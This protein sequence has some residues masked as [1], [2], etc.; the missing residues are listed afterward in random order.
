MTLLYNS[1][2][3]IAIPN[4]AEYSNDIALFGGK[5]MKTNPFFESHVLAA[6]QLPFLFHLDDINGGF[7]VEP[8]WHPNMELLL[9]MKGEVVAEI[10]AEKFNMAP[11]EIYVVNSDVQHRMYSSTSGQYYCL[12]PD[13]KFCRLLGID[14]DKLYI[15]PRIQDAHAK[16]LYEAIVHTFQT[17]SPYREAEVKHAVFS[18]L[19]Y[20]SQHYAEEKEKTK[21]YTEKDEGVRIAVGYIRAHLNENF[22]LEELA[23][24]A[25]LS[26]FYFLRE[27]K[28]ATGD[29]P[30]AFIHKNR[31]EVAKALLLSGDLSAGE[32]AEQCGFESLSYF[33]RIF[34]KYVG[35][36]PGAYRRKS[37]TP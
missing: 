20:L 30:V 5:T 19:L 17:D 23:A 3:Q 1:C 8:H 28:K 29:T 7:W 10:G 15:A 21:D 22:T 35:C 37:I 4:V 2:E 34:K 12:I 27:F 31:C 18:L 36:T 14:T 26:K 32:I 9:F 33:G 6:R 24:E 25:G 11:G 16:A 13:S